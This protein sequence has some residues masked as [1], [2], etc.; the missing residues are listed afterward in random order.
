[1]KTTKGIPPIVCED[2]ELTLNVEHLPKI[3]PQYL[4]CWLLPPHRWL[5]HCC[6]PT[7]VLGK[8][9]YLLVKYYL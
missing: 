4:S 1:M 2:M 9:L 8:G 7:Y 6:F 5:H 3:F